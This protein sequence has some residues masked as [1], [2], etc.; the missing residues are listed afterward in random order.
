MFIPPGHTRL[1]DAVDAIASDSD[2]E[3]LDAER[4]EL[5]LRRK[6]RLGLLP[7]GPAMD[8]HDSFFALRASVA[9]QRL[10]ADR[11]ERAREAA[12]TRLCQALGTPIFSAIGVDALG[13]MCSIPAEPW[14]TEPGFAALKSGALE[15]FHPSRSI[16][17]RLMVFLPI[18]AF[19]KWR[20]AP[21]EQS[22]S[23]AAETCLANVLTTIMIAT[24]STPCSKVDVKADPRV[25]KFKVSDR[26]FERAWQAALKKSDAAAW[27]KPG[28]RKKNTPG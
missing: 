15:L 27:R 12:R 17:Q 13:Y 5:E 7:D 1:L 14:R 16:P 10:V 11:A 2:R 18:A 26:G 6:N 8:A 20:G 9:R 22:M 3:A 28:R 24:P 19:E 25:I 21:G 23:I 4:E